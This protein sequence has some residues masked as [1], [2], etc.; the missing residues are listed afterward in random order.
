M[1]RIVLLLGCIGALAWAQDRGTETFPPFV[2]RLKAQAS[3]HSVLLTWRNPVDATAAKLVYRSSEE[4]RTETLS[5]ATLVARLESGSD[6]FEDRPPD[7]SP[8]YY[9]VLLESPAG[10]PFDVLIPFRNKTSQSVQTSGSPPE[11]ALATDITELR[12]EVVDDSVRVAFRS[13]RPERELLLFR[14]TTPMTTGDDLLAADA[15]AFLEAGVQEYRDLPIP[16]VEVYYAVVDAGLFKVGETRIV[17]GQNATQQPVQIPLTVQRVALPP[18][19]TSRPVPLPYLGPS[20]AT[21]GGGAQSPDLLVPG[22]AR[23][24]QPATAEALRGLLAQS[25]VRE[26]PPRAVEVLPEDR[27]DSGNEPGRSLS[28]ILQRQLQP[29]HYA[30]AETALRGLLSIRRSPQ[31]EARIH[32]YIGQSLYMQRL[33]REA[34]LEFVLARD[35]IYAHVQ[36]WLEDSLRLAAAR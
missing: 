15:P 8:Y 31:A 32:F 2:S 28:E 13:S 34:A 18:A 16:G 7:A 9:A 10:K 30:E 1:R 6:S 24:L 4:I 21:A 5:A 33:Y 23:P 25:P 27:A 22:K 12:T 26:P 35:P 36:P 11:E 17:A 19:S 20:A 14:S 29:G 3:Q